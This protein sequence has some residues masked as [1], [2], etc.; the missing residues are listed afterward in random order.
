MT[1]QIFAWPLL[2][3]AQMAATPAVNPTAAPVVAAAPIVVA[4]AVDRELSSHDVQIDDMFPI[5][6]DEP[7]V[8]DNRVVLP[9]GLTGEGQVVHASRAK[10]LGKGGELIVAARYLQC[11]PMRIA[12]RGFRLDGAGDDRTGTLVAATAV[13]GL[14]ATPL[15]FMKGGESI[16]PI[17]TVG[18][19]KLAGPLPIVAEGAPP[20]GG[21]PPVLTLPATKVSQQGVTQ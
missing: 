17:R 4:I 3:I 19:A 2:A 7:L 6:I 5:K 12:L 11:G 15:M 8:I 18:H 13:V 1:G 14:I 20:C 10:G 16:I 9:A 21:A